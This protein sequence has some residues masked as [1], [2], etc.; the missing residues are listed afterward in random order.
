MLGLYK[1]NQITL[2]LQE[3]L[4]LQQST[5]KMQFE[6]FMQLRGQV[7][8]DAPSR[9]TSKIIIDNKSYYIKQHLGVGWLEIIKNLL[10]FK[11]P[12]VSAK[13]EMLA[14]ELLGKNNILTTPLV[15]FGECGY[16]P[17]TKQSFVLTRDLGDIV[18]LE[19][20]CANWEQTPPKLKLK[21]MLIKKVAQLAAK[22]HGAGLFHRDFYLCHICFQIDQIESLDSLPY[23]LDLHRA[24]LSIKINRSNRNKDL[25][26]LYFSALHI[27][28]TKRDI[29]LF[30]K[31]YSKT[32]LSEAI[33]KDSVLDWINQR[34]LKLD[35]KFQRKIRAGER[36]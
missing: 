9:L 18:S 22:M 34:A 23:L 25:A 7:C 13:N 30:I 29:L 8:R 5:L 27:G 12:I 2:L 6:Y 15:A 32:A 14:I 20:Y 35:A 31:T 11:M 17:A 33:L 1:N 21:R 28:L 36:L 16:N 24:I 26:A 19:T 4:A 3:D 10:F